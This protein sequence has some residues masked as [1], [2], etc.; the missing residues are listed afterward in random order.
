M[1]LSNYVTNRFVFVLSF[2]VFIHLFVVS[3]VF[4]INLLNGFLFFKIMTLVKSDYFDLGGLWTVK[5]QQKG[6]M[7]KKLL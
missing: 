2:E 4:K 5:A 7:E 6:F 3:S 1:L